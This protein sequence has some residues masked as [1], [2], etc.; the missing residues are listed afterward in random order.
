MH[1]TLSS[2]V[3]RAL[4]GNQR[5][6][7][8]YLRDNSRLPGPR[9]NLELAD[10]VSSLL[11]TAVSRHPERVKSLLNYFSNSDHS[12]VTGNTPSEFVL[13]CGIVASGACAAVQPGWR[14][15][16]LSLLD[17]YASSPYWRVREGVSIAYRHML[18]ADSDEMIRHMLHLAREGCCLQQRAAIAAVAEPPLLLSNYKLCISALELQRIVLH[19]LHL[20]P[21]NERKREDFRVLRR[22]LGYT[23]S[24][25]TA[26]LPEE[27]FALMSEAVSWGDTDI[28]WVLR[29][30]LKKK[31]L[32]K[33]SEHTAMLSRLLAEPWRYW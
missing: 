24:V 8:F 22:T 9:P 31:R 19:R 2:L 6:L 13:L 17:Q 32:A 10:D 20:I 4:T 27:G 11:A 5:P 21:L 14:N 16:T 18:V 28:V 3:E 30:N 15:E 26:A 29:E 1:D 7:E 23:L 25:V 12:A 33:F